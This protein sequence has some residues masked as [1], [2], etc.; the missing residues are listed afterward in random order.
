MKF[1]LTTL[2]CKVNQYESQRIRE[3][4]VARGHT[5]QAFS[6]PGADCYIINTCTVTHRSD[7][8]GRK[9]IRA[10]LRFEGRVVVTGC[11]AEVY[12]DDISAVSDRV[13]IVRQE[14]MA[15]HFDVLLPPVITSFGG[16]SR[17][18]VQVQSGCNNFCT[19]CIVAH[20][21]GKPWSRP[22]QEVVAEIDALERSGYKEVVLCGINIGLYEG[23]IAALLRQILA[24]TAIPRVRISSIEPWTVGDELVELL[25][26]EPRVCKHL[27]L[28]LQSGSDEILQK[29]G[30]PYTAGYFSDLVHRLKSADSG[31][32]IG[33]DVM[34]GFPGEEQHHFGE[35][36]SLLERLDITYLHVFPYSARPKTK[37]AA[38]PRQVDAAT[39]RQRAQV[40]RDLSRAKREAFIRSQMGRSEDIVVTR[41][42]PGSF[43]GIT[44]NYLAVR[45]Q[46]SACLNDLVRVCLVDYDGHAV[47]GMPCG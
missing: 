33:S 15:S 46:G 18:F 13:E 12:P 34:V 39:K 25:S 45:V 5:E 28:P 21:R 17:A 27:H 37:A 8:E 31:I 20:A 42:D 1:A 11:Q 41:T 35:S 2:G 26:Q 4:L 36:Y 44:S 9:L 6:R 14:T 16:H 29:M 3:A 32:A 19:F 7:A 40:L 43:G 10:A 23:G 30:R 22:W 24:H 47:E 38:M